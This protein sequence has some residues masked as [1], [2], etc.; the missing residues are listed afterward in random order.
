M[1]KL[2]VFARNTGRHPYIAQGIMPVL[3]RYDINND[4]RP[5]NIHMA[6]VK[7]AEQAVNFILSQF[8]R[9]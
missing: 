7:T 1:L 3:L 6:W 4:N 8:G 2:C 5:T 9:L